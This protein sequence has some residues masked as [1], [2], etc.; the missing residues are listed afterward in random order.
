MDGNN[1][2]N[3]IRKDKMACTFEKYELLNH[4]LII[5]FQ[6]HKNEILYESN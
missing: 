1:L 2:E 4:I 5:G 3:L 6:N